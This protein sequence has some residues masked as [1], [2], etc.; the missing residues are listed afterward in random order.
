VDRRYF[1]LDA[2]PSLPEMTRAAIEVLAR[3]GKGFFLMVEGGNIDYAGH[4]NDAG[5]MLQE[6]L[7]LDGAVQVAA[8]FQSKVPETLIVVTA[9]HGTGGFSFTY[10]DWGPPVKIDLPSGL[11][12]RTDHQYPTADALATLG[13]QRASYD[14][15]LDMAGSSP[16]RLVETVKEL[17]GLVLTPEEARAALVRDSE[18]HA[19]TVDFRPF[20]GDEESNPSCLLGRALAPHTYV[21]WSTGGHTIDPVLTFGRGPGAERLRGVYPD[22]FLYTVMKEVLA[23]SP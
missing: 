2:V 21:V 5:S 13:R 19:W 15:M 7:E 3:S 17:T 16:D 22:T 1:G 10:G 11:Q 20:Y 6:I 18:G 8:E 14:T 4:D 12:Y 9:D 23:G